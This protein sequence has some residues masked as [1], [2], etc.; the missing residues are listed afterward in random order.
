MPLQPSSRRLGPLDSRFEQGR[1]LGPMDGSNTVLVGTA[2]GVVKP[3]QS[4]G[5]RPANN[6]LAACWTKHRAAN[7]HQMHWKTMAA[8]SGSESLCCSHMRQF[9]YLHWCPNF[10]KCD[11][12]R[13][14]EL[15]LSSSATQTIALG[16][17]ARAGRKQ[18]VDHSE[19]CRSRM[20]AIL[21]TT[22]EGHGRL[23]RARDR[24]AQAANEPRK[25]VCVA[26]LVAHHIRDKCMKLGAVILTGVFNMAFKRETPSGDFGERPISLLEAACQPR[27]DPVAYF[28]HHTAVGSRSVSPAVVCGLHVA[29]L[30]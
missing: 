2:S 1:Y 25:S 8:E 4:N 24:F 16:A 30:W 12:R 21:M 7:K 17:N 18:A 14:A 10:G 6:E 28:R 27:Q 3:E 22:T 13:Y 26:L 15:T 23:E 20:E 9:L 19:Q 29:D 11:E 5:C